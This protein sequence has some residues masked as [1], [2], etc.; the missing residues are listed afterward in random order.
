MPRGAWHYD[1][2]IDLGFGGFLRAAATILTRDPLFDW[3]AYGGVLTMSEDEFSVI[4]RDG[5]RKRFHIVLA[6]FR[7]MIELDRDGFAVERPIVVARDMGRVRMV[8]EN[9]TSDEHV[10]Q[11]RVSLRD[12]ALGRE[13]PREPG[14]SRMAYAVVQDGRRMGAVRFGEESE[15]ELRISGN[16]TIVELV[17]EREGDQRN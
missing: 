15:I 5:L 8:I 13:S 1:G 16:T 17:R 3:F 10:T 2:E 14:A 12:A 9:R 11:L 7:M 6:D 4:P